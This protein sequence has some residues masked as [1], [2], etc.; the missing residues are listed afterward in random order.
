MNVL[1]WFLIALYI[2][3]E[4]ADV[5]LKANT[6]SSSGM[7]SSWTGGDVDGGSMVD[8][9]GGVGQGPLL[10]AKSNSLAF[11]MQSSPPLEGGGFVQFLIRSCLPCPHDGLHG[12]KYH[13]DQSP[14][15]GQGVR[16]QS[17]DS[18][19]G[20]E[21]FNPLYA[22]GGLSHTRILYSF[23]GPQPA[24][25]SDQSDQ[26]DQFPLTGQGV[27]LHTFISEL[28]P[29]QVL[30]PCAGGGLSQARCLILVPAPHVTLQSAH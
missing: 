2:R 3:N 18:S 17:R 10:Q 15:T 13:A 6:M 11:P 1:M 19:F 22:G 14:S 26:V 28:G 24:E 27:A 29:W 21:Q 7:L 25:H 12:V 8:T 5:A 20:P 30:P 4:S 16:L 9:G 23:P